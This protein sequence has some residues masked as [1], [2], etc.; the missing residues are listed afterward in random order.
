MTLNISQITNAP[1]RF[2][3]AAAVQAAP[4]PQSIPADTVELSKKNVK[5]VQEL[6]LIR[7]LQSKPQK[8]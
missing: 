1:C 2:T 5:K 6:L 3:G 7:S 4:K 8:A